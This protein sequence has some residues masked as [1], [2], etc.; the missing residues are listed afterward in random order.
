MVSRQYADINIDFAKSLIMFGV[1]TVSQP[2]L[3]RVNMDT[4]KAE[5]VL[6]TPL[7]PQRGFKKSRG[8]FGRLGAD[9]KRS[10]AISPII[11]GLSSVHED[12]CAHV[13]VFIILTKYNGIRA[14]RTQ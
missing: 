12:C 2:R 7:D 6:A 11:V 9:V 13:F 10:W 1:F 3:R 14:Y 4:Y 8:P 5:K